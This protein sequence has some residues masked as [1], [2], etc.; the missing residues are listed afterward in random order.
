MAAEPAL[1]LVMPALDPGIHPLRKNKE[2]CLK[3][4][5]C[6]IQARQ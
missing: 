6:R 4:M 2:R 3:K 1:M 5:D